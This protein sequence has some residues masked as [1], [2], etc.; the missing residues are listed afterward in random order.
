MAQ[1]AQGAAGRE[2]SARAFA[3]ATVA[4]PPEEVLERFARLASALHTRAL[5]AQRQNR[6]LR[7][8]LDDSLR[9]LGAAEAL[10]R[11]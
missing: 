4:W 9:T 11:A 2:L 1:L 8:L 6:T 10:P 3:Q 7:A 5:M